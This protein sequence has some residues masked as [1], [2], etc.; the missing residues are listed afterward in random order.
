MSQEKKG[1]DFSQVS[2]LIVEDSPYM[3]TIIKIILAGLG[4]RNVREAADGV[5]AFRVLKGTPVDIV[6]VD[7]E[8]PMLN[9]VEF[10]R[11]VRTSDDSPNPYLPMIMVSGHSEMRRIV[12][13]RDSGVNEFIV[14]PLSAKMLYSR[15]VSVIENPRPF[16]RTKAFFGPD[17]RRKLPEGYKGQERREELLEK[18]KEF[19]KE[20]LTQV[21][22]DGVVYSG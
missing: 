8:M 19:G 15:L 10:V 1:Y 22:I 7:W 16:I 12:E 13:A 21:E 5:D 20:S 4:F 14:K 18:L 11:M 2:V 6:L 9:G 17:R 3:R